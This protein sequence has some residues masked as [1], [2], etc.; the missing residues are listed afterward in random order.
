MARSHLG[1]GVTVCDTAADLPSSPTVG[2]IVHRVDTDEYLKYIAY[3]GANRWMRM[4]PRPNRNRI[5]NG[6]FAVSQRNTGSVAL[7][8]TI[9]YLNVDR[10]G[11]YMATSNGTMQR[12]TTGLPTNATDGVQFS[13]GLRI[14]RNSGSTSTSQIKFATAL[15]SANSIMNESQNVTLSFWAKAGANFSSASVVALV[16]CSTGTDQS[17]TNMANG[18]WSGMTV[19][20]TIS[21]ASSSMGSGWKFYTASGTAPSNVNQIGVAIYFNPTSGAAGADDNLYITGVQ[22][23]NSSAPSEFEFEPY[24]VTLRKCQ[25]YW[26]QSYAHG[27]V[28]GTATSTGQ[29][30]GSAGRNANY[31]TGPYIAFPATMRIAPTV[32]VYNTNGTINNLYWDAVGTAGEN[33]ASN[34]ASISPYGFYPASTA[35]TNFRMSVTGHYTASAEL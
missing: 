15:E 16:Y 33:I 18:L 9:G 35:L 2:Q 3:G 29:W 13:T 20:V 11:G 25:R 6:H 34:A 7:P 31:G 24:D 8:T 19:P 17:L 4:D 12:V 27:T 10:W 32:T 1:L 26:N 14:G 21:F 23:E 30:Q 5:I 22:L 28:A